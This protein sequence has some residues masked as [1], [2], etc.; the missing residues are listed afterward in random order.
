MGSEASVRGI[1]KITFPDGTKS[2]IIGLDAVIEELYRQGKPAN[3][4]TATEM[5]EKL[6]SYNY[7]PPSQRHIYKHLFIEE[8]RHFCE[9]Q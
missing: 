6:E 7:I 8:Y 2:G 5:M 9:S 3:D 1:R 4:S